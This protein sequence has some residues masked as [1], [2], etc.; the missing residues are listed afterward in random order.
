MKQQAIERA[1]TL[2]PTPRVAARSGLAATLGRDWKLAYLLLLPAAAVMA[3]LIAYPFAYSIWLSL[4]NIRV[5]GAAHF[6]GLSNYASLLAG[7]NHQLFWSSVAV[8]VQYVVA[9]EVFKFIIGITSALIL[10]SAVRGRTLWRA[11][12][13]LPWSVPAVVSAYAWRWIYDD[14]LG[15]VN[16]VLEHFGLIH[17]PVLF[18]SSANLALWSVIAASVWQGTPFWT[19]TYLAGLQSIPQELYEAARI[20]GAG[21]VQNFL[22]ITMPSLRPVIIVTFMLSSIWTAN[23]LQYVYILTNGGPANATQTFPLLAYTIGMRSYNLGMAAAVPLLFFPLF[24]VIILA[25]TRRM[26][27]ERV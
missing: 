18:L 17:Q 2:V 19:M 27:R 21:P 9:A 12:L 26:L 5:G 1:A 15:M 4:N 7:F 14:R 16:I 3:G 10:H 6:V 23:G 20:D 25:L 22:H 8:T 11:L 24:A 13:F